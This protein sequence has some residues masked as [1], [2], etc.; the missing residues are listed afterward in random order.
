[1]VDR[2]EISP[3]EWQ[4]MNAVW[5]D[6]PV[7]AGDIIKALGPANDWT[8]QTIRTFLHRLVKKGALTFE[9]DGNRYLYRAAVKRSA[10]VKRA[11][12]S[13]L[14]SVF[15]GETGPLLTHFVKSSKLTAEQIQELRKLLEEKES[16]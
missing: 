13:F 8:A 12:R 9:K 3:S 11:S 16:Q 4:V 7:T 6:Q 5:A 15:D 2:P 1:M 14:S 10:T